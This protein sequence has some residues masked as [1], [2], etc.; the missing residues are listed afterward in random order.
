MVT[1]A[2]SWGDIP[3]LWAHVWKR[4]AATILPPHLLLSALLSL[5]FGFPRPWLCGA[6][7][8]CLAAMQYTLHQLAGSIIVPASTH[9]RRNMAL[10]IRL[11]SWRRFAAHAQSPACLPACLPVPRAYA[12]CPR[13]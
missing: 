1:Y 3:G 4:R 13:M 10:V 11:L 9:T 12:C 7:S 2:A 8:V 5:T 6:A